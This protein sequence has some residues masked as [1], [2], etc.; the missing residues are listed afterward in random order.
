MATL[1]KIEFI[2]I[3]KVR[4][5]GRQVSHSMEAGVENP[6]PA[7]W[8]DSFDDGSVEKLKKLPLVIEGCTI[9]WMGDFDGSILSI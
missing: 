3:P 8:E 4:I 6:V 9:G 7:L 5:I 2:K 1:E